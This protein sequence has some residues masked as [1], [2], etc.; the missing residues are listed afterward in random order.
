MFIPI[1]AYSI[2]SIFDILT[3]VVVLNYQLYVSEA[4]A[5]IGKDVFDMKTA[6]FQNHFNSQLLIS[7][8]V[9]F[10]LNYCRC[11]LSADLFSVVGILT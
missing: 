8:R 10:S 4:L 5:F 7:D 11:C 2:L 9:F 6:F 1:G 3:F